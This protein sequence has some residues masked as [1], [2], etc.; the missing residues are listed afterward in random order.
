MG[1]G[2]RR[3]T[4]PIP[5]MYRLA[6]MILADECPP[7][8]SYYLCRM[9]CQGELDDVCADCWH[10]RP[11][12]HRARQMV[13][14]KAPAKAG[15]LPKADAGGQKRRTTTRRPAADAEEI[16]SAEPRDRPSQ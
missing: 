11:V 13:G 6:L 15:A 5:S 2:Q 9:G 16:M 10:G 3:R 1:A 14:K 7:D 4:A 12:P 8:G